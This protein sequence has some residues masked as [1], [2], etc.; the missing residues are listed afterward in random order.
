MCVGTSAN[1]NMDCTVSDNWAETVCPAGSDACVKG[2]RG[3]TVVRMCGTK[4][5]DVN[6]GGDP[7]T[8]ACE[9]SATKFWSHSIYT[10]TYYDVRFIRT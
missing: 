3:D 6:C 10:H 4:S 8:C 5:Q 2:V 9:A 1:N 7:G